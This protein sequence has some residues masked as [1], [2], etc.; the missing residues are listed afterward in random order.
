MSRISGALSK[1]DDDS[2]VRR[3][4]LGFLTLVV[5]YLL[6]F[7]YV[8]SN[9][10][11]ATQAKL[12]TQL[13]HQTTEIAVLTKQVESLG[14]VPNVQAFLPPPMTT[15][16]PDIAPAPSA[17]VQAPIAPPATSPPSA[18]FVAPQGTTAPSPAP[19]A[20]PTTSPTT[21][22][23]RT[24]PTTAPCRTMVLGVCLAR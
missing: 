19:T 20:A 24:T 21:V 22:P 6:A 4:S 10:S 11:A 3:A 1:L 14:G 8:A 13:Q 23:H 9:Q 17:P 15:V 16:V 12:L 5:I 18:P 7:Q 2:L